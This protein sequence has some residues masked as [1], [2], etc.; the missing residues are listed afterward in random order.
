M[1]ENEH[2]KTCVSF[3]QHPGQA[4]LNKAPNKG[5]QGKTKRE[6][7]SPSQKQKNPK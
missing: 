1:V 6:D 4:S 7:E 3:D 5:V 2:I